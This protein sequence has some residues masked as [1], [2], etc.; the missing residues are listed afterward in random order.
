MEYSHHIQRTPYSSIVQL[1]NSFRLSITSLAGCKGTAFTHPLSPLHLFHSSAIFTAI[2]FTLQMLRW[3]AC[4][5]YL[6]SSPKQPIIAME[7]T[8]PLRFICY[9]RAFLSPFS[10][11]CW[12]NLFVLWKKPFSS[13]TKVRQCPRILS[14]CFESL[15]FKLAFVN[16]SSFNASLHQSCSYRRF[17][18]LQSRL[19]EV[20]ECA[21]ATDSVITK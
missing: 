18:Y 10:S 12:P 7:W 20:F 21:S 4:S 8:G 9:C 1:C 16:S 15:N 11:D 19:H 2:D 13:S 3:W 14:T 17:I 6:I 5:V